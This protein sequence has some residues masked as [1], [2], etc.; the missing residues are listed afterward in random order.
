MLREERTSARDSCDDLQQ[1]RRETRTATAI[2]VSEEL[3]SMASSDWEAFGRRR[4]ILP[5]Y[6]DLAVATSPEKWVVAPDQAGVSMS[7][8]LTRLP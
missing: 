7:A 5:K 6:N 4:R 2:E 1:F 8:Y 3:R